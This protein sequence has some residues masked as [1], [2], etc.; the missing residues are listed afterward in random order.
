[1]KIN[2]AYDVKIKEYRHIFDETVK[3]YRKAVDFLIDV[4]DAHWDEVSVIDGAKARQRFVET[5]VHT[6]K[7]I[8]AVYAFDDKFCK[9]PSYLRRAAITC[10]IGKVSSWKSNLSN[11]EKN[12]V[13]KQPRKPTAGNTFPVLY[14]GDCFR[15]LE[16]DMYTCEIKV[17][18]R[19]T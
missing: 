13:G 3:V 19:N 16:G 17:F 2:S 9:F 14:R 10:A 7:N 4:C 12:P 11:W 1:M 18:I 5:L 8:I 15:E 6:T